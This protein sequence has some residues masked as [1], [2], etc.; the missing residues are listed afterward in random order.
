MI[1]FLEKTLDLSREYAS[2]S[3]PYDHIAD[4]MIDDADEGLTTAAIQRL[5]EEL[6]REL[7]PMVRAICDQPPPEDGCLHRSFGEAAQLDFGLS[8]AAQMGYDLERG[9]LDKTHQALCDQSIIARRGNVRQ[10]RPASAGQNC[11]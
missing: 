1:P 2:F 3:A 5:F 6:R 4:P 10:S 9:R 8:V 7:L 11:S